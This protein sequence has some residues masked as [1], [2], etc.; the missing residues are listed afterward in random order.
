M[1]DLNVHVPRCDLCHEKMFLLAFSDQGFIHTADEVREAVSCGL[2][3]DYRILQIAIDQGVSRELA[4]QA[5]KEGLV[6]SEESDWLI[7]DICTY[8][9]AKFFKAR[10][11]NFEAHTEEEA[12]AFA[13]NA[14]PIS[15]LISLHVAWPGPLAFVTARFKT[16]LPP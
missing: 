9:N 13:R 6:A 7:C 14:I 5:W 4:I 11:K 1:A 10:R 8:L 12:M 16:G 15:K 3:P 2:E